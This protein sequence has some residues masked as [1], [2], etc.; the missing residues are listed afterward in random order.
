MEKVDKNTV[1]EEVLTRGVDKIYPSRESLQEALV[2]GKKLTIYLGADPTGSHL[3]LGHATNLLT[4]KR[5]HE[6]GHKII[7]LIGDFTGMI[8]DPSGKSDTRK[9][10]TEKEVSENL[11]TFKEQVARVLDFKGKNSVKLMFN[12][13]WWKN[14]K[15]YELASIASNFTVQQMIQRD[16][17][18]ERIKEDKPISLQ[19]FF[20]PLFQGYDSVEMDVDMEIGGTDQTFNMLIGRDLMKIYKNKN[21]FVLTTK[22]LVNPKTGKKLMNKS[23]GGLIN[24]D[25]EPNDMFGKVMA[26]DDAVMFDVAELC[27]SMPQIELNEL[28]KSAA[29]N[30]RDAKAGI[31]FWVVKTYHGEKAAKEAQAEFDKVF[32]N[33]ELPEEIPEFKIGKREIG[34]VDLLVETKLASSKGEARRLIEQGGVK[35]DGEK[36]FDMNKILSIP[37]K[38]ILL[39]VGKRHFVR[40]I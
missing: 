1:L 19:E 37:P 25:D 39:Q 27:T 3:H 7:F 5:F 32:K 40:V 26:I 13:K 11:R 17:F 16:M 15:V 2:S 9:Q 8:G 31:A 14:M 6:L 33:K 22:L 30:P 4:L 35:I 10:L 20:Y 28:K 38:G 29:L 23:E 24:L 21:K 36:V 12:S 34:I 18:Q